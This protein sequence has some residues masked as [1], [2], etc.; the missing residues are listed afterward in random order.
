[1]SYDISLRD[2][3]GDCDEINITWNYAPHY[4]RVFAERPFRDDAE[5]AAFGYAQRL[6][7][8][9]VRTI[10]G[11]TGAQSTPVLQAAIA[12]LG[13]DFDANYWAPTEGNARRAL[14]KLLVMAQKRPAG[15]WEGD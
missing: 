15:V 2:P 4:Y 1:M 7:M 10:Y 8:G 14:N 3:D 13:D 6:V 9:G 5:C 11:T 12:Q